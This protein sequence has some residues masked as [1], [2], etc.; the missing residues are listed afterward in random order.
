MQTWAD[1][2]RLLEVPP[3]AFR[4]M[5][6]VRSAVIRLAWRP[7]DIAIPSVAAFDLVS[8]RIFQQRRKQLGNALH[9]LAQERGAEAAAWLAGAAL[10]ATRR[11]GT[12]T[13]PELARLAAVVGG[14]DRGPVV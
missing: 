1:V 9:G 11:P 14:G 13:R 5:P 2:T 12:L 3:G 8:R 7:A 6:K 4:P 10:D